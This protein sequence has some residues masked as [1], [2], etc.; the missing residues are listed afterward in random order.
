MFAGDHSEG[1][2]EEQMELLL[3]LNEWREAGKTAGGK[4]GA[5]REGKEGRET[6]SGRAGVSKR[7]SVI[8]RIYLRKKGKK[9]FI[10]LS[11]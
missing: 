11:A 2:K 1:L 10:V 7:N 3:L 9:V 5:E 8:F 6:T 4:D